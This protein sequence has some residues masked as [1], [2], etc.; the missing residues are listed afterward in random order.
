M[1]TTV[2]ALEWNVRDEQPPSNLSEFTNRLYGAA[3]SIPAEYRE[4]ASIDLDPYYDC[5]GDQFPQVRVTY[6]RPMT[7][8]E[9][10]EY[11][12][13]ESEHWAE[14]LRNAEER[15]CYCRE[16]LGGKP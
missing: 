15:V 10:A 2:T 8:T 3:L 11:A 7:A 9:L 6:T 5:A 1:N 14:Q 12:R 4:S 16:Q 13:E